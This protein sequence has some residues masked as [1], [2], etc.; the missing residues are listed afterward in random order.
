MIKLAAQTDTMICD[1]GGFEDDF[2]FY[3][4]AAAFYQLGSSYCIPRDSSSQPVVWSSSSL[5]EFRRFQI[6]TTGVDTLTGMN[7]TKFGNKS[8]LI[9][10]RY[11]HQGPICQGAS[12]V[13]KLIKRFTVTEENRHF[14]VW[15]AVVL[16]NPA[17]HSDN[18][19]FFSIK[20]DRAPSNDLCIDASI[21]PC[22]QY[23][24]DSI[25][26][27]Q[28]A[29]TAIDA[30]DWT[31]HRIT[32]PANFIDSIATLEVTGADCGLYCHF[33][34]AYIDGICEECTGSASGSVTLYEFDYDTNS[35]IGIKYKSC[36][37]DTIMICGSYT[38]PTYCGNWIMD[39]IRIYNHTIFDLTVDTSLK[40]FCFK[41]SK[42]DFPA[43]S[44]REILA[45]IFFHS[46]LSNYSM[47]VSN[48]IEICNDDF[49][50]YLMDVTVGSCQ[51][52]NTGGLLSDDYYYLNIII[53]VNKGDSWSIERQLDNPYPNE[54]GEYIMRTGNGPDT[55]NL[56]PILIQEGDW[57]LTLSI[58]NCILIYEITSPSF[59]SGCLKFRAAEI[60]DVSCNDQGTGTA[61][62]D[63]WSFYLLVP[64][65]GT[66]M[67][68]GAGPYSYGTP[69]LVS[70]GTIVDT[71]VSFNLEDNVISFCNSMVIVCPPKPCS[72]NENCELEVYITDVYCEEEDSEYY[73]E[74]NVS[75]T[76][77]GYTCY[78]ATNISGTDSVEGRF[79]SNI[80]GPFDEEI[81]LEIKKCTTIACTCSAPECFKILYVPFP[82]CEN[83]EFRTK[84]TSK[85]NL[86]LPDL[87]MVLPNPLDRN[88]ILLKSSMNST[89]FEIFNSSSALIY[90]GSFSGDTYRLQLNIP[91]GVYFVRY[92]DEE[93]RQGYIKV[94]RAQ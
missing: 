36:N 27:D 65:S 16:E 90:K 2:D 58:G 71:C 20:C 79:I 78:K 86:S 89:K 7:R 72:D 18:Q 33:G 15:Y 62:D 10:N 11:A 48:I 21:L 6:V 94:I 66:F 19:P 8:L 46:N 3:F 1:N 81:W 59:C 88:E 42:S 75:G 67:I 34:Y 17:A 47:Q 35:K 4:G 23:Y 9:N 70:V 52:N 50:E 40:I 56:G 80:L 26:K 87:L 29:Y 32:I 93:G 37:G 12:D 92:K 41:L 73:I 69:Q 30:V 57:E 60:Y 74:L 44:C 31:C 64:G 83:L 91:P 39:S 55:I 22:E 5:P 14:T 76:G 68:N 38:K 61:S 28:S 45:N 51:D 53:S 63:T 85:S 84:R 82:D 43:D 54:S 77:S 49:E 25:C 24:L 13:N